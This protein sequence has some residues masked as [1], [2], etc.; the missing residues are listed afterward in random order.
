M[1][2]PF[3]SDIVGI[4]GAFGFWPLA[5][6]FPIKMYLSR[7]NIER[8]KMEQKLGWTSSAS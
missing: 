6:Y 1:S 7:N 8:W 4:L 3:F 2:L 5:V